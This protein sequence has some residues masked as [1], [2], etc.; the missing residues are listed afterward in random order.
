M[1]KAKSRNRVK[2][3]RLWKPIARIKP[4]KLRSQVFRCF[5]KPLLT[6]K[7]KGFF[8]LEK[9]AVSTLFNLTPKRVLYVGICKKCQRIEYDTDKEN[10]KDKLQTHLER[11]H[12]DIPTLASSMSL[13]D[14]RFIPKQPLE[15]PA[16][17]LI[18]RLTNQQEV[19]GFLRQTD[20]S[21]LY[22]AIKQ[23]SVRTV[24]V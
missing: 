4:L 7:P 13:N 12:K 23:Q 17:F 19:A 9:T 6:V 1:R 2:Q 24:P 21:A 10:F 16:V 11:S 3:R 22:K 5:S 8:S 20:S 14:Y 18:T 15:P